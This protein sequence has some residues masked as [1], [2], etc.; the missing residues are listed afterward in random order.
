MMC[1]CVCDVDVMMCG[2]VCDVLFVK[3]YMP[4]I[5]FITHTAGDWTLGDV[6]PIFS[7]CAATL[8]VCTV[9]LGPWAERCVYDIYV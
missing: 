8:G 4:L 6:L 3:C 9:L 2:C 1:G 5:S 7:Y